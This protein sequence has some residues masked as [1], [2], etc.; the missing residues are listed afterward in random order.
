M[1][2]FSS[3]SL[4]MVFWV[5]AG[6]VTEPKV[7]LNTP[8]GLFKLGEFYQKQER[9][10]EAI[11]QYKTLANKHPYSKLAVEAEL[12]VADCQFKQEDFVE[13]Y[14]AYKTFKELH[15]KHPLMDYVTFRA[16]E[17]LREDLP[18]TVDRDL[19]TA[20]QAINYYDEI[21]A[22]YPSS[23]YAADAKE[24]RFQLIQMLADKELYIADFYFK[25]EKYM[26]ALSRYELFLQ[27]FP[28][29]KR[30]PYALLRASLAAKKANLPDRIML[31]S[32]RLISEF[33]KSTEAATAKK[34]F[35]GVAR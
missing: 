34:E 3:I 24:R 20:S 5:F 9:Y 18:S 29:N 10:E 23:K 28:Q 27:S 25:Q 14:A 17:S 35:P 1:K 31:H 21:L 12:R 7:N 32:Q 16:A 8:E 6:C 11:T 2:V 13:A 19:T 15:P 22:L 30:V 33:P 4:L 26:G